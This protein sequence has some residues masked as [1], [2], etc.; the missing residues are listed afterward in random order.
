MGT[1]PQ[2]ERAWQVQSP[3]GRKKFGTL[4]GQQRPMQVE[5]STEWVG[6]LLDEIREVS[7]HQIRQGLMVREGVRILF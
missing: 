3:G 5:P 7:W 1:A 6:G 4:E 2:A